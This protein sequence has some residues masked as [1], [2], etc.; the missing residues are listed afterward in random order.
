MAGMTRR[1]REPFS[2]EE[3]ALAAQLPRLHGRGE[4]TP[5]LD[6]SILGAAR[7]AVGPPPALRPRIR[8]IAPM[9][10]AASL[11]L[12]VGLAW[13]LQPPPTPGSAAG[14][15]APV[16]DTANA[17]MPAVQGPVSAILPGQERHAVALP[18]PSS[19]SGDERAR[20]SDAIPAP[21][22]A[23]QVLQA[24]PPPAPPVPPAPSAS[25]PMVAAETN[26]AA[27]MVSAP[28]TAP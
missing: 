3:H 23:Q 26:A 9:A 17:V 28:P 27:D 16:A 5:A 13:R 12:A 18:A 2:A 24:A 21:K 20:A 8:W 1:P 4:P 11:S 15:V 10:V 7:A 19:R 22:A 6:A 25:A 14:T